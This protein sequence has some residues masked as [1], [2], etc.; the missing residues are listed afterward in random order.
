MNALN[1]VDCLA[2][3]AEAS[4]IANLTETAKFLTSENETFDQLIR[5]KLKTGISYPAARAEVVAELCGENC[6]AVL[7]EPNNILAVEYL[8]A[9][10]SQNSD[11]TPILINRK[12][13][14]HDDTQIHGNFA[15]ASHIRELIKENGLQSAQHLVPPE[16]AEL[17]K[18]AKI[19]SMQ[20]IEVAVLANLR[21]MTPELI[22]QIPD[23]SEGLENRIFEAAKEHKTLGKV[24]DA[25]QTKRYTYS[26]IR[27]IM[28]HSYLEVTRND[29]ISP[30]YLR[31]LDF[32]P[33]GQ[34]I[35]N[36]IKKET[37]LP[38]TKNFSQLKK[39]GSAQAIQM[40]EQ[41]LV[42]DNLYELC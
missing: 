24:I 42:F 15:S 9:L 33:Q 34:E 11:I 38:L 21:R 17:Y 18:S 26:R 31:I 22:A 13:V 37:T 1:C 7:R 28:L 41:E 14:K 16:C 29:L 20:A 8:K 40:W 10:I 36:G 39:Q 30:Q 5:E 2:F 19:H 12:A 6:A 25:I 3:G 23:V 4:D 32:S 35:L 27:R